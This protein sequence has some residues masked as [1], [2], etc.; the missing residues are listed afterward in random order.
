MLRKPERLTFLCW[1]GTRRAHVSLLLR[2]LILDFL[3]F[4]DS[5]SFFKAYKLVQNKLSVRRYVDS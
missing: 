2:A 5:Y 4:G 3:E 1:V